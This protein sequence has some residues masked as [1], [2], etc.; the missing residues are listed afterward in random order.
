M[1]TINFEVNMKQEIIRLFRMNL[2]KLEQLLTNYLKKDICCHGVSIAQCHTLLAVEQL[3]QIS[4]NV[5][6]GFMGLDK[7]TLS[8]TVE[9]LV[10]NELLTRI[11]DSADRRITLISLTAKG[12]L[13]CDEINRVN[14][15]RFSKI[16]TATH[17]NPTELV[18]MFSALVKA[19]AEAEST[20][21]T[22]TCE[23]K[24]EQSNEIRE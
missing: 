6:S 8:R 18:E 3:D 5:L 15:E 14:D 20:R 23:E 13:I 24:K 12:R 10:G 7:S 21:Q 19:M 2:R 4:L 1:I 11:T 16:L 9:G 17:K 22:C